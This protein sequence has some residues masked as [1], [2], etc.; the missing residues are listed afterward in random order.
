[1]EYLDPTPLPGSSDG[2]GTGQSLC[3]LSKV[4]LRTCNWTPPLLLSRQS[5][6]SLSLYLQLCYL[7][8]YFRLDCE[9]L[10][11]PWHQAGHY[12][13][14]RPF[15]PLII[16]SSLPPTVSLSMFTQHVLKPNLDI[17]RHR[18]LNHISIEQTSISRV[19]TSPEV[20]CERKIRAQ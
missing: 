2:L 3:F 8:V 9:N 19:A 12:P 14:S 20:G 15:S 10:I 5:S 6:H 18:I 13:L 7:S 11:W 1:M 16:L 4:K 17:F